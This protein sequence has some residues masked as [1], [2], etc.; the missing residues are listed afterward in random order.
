MGEE[1]FVEVQRRVD[2]IEFLPYEVVEGYE[3]QTV[4]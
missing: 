1:M 2:E 3:V 4:F